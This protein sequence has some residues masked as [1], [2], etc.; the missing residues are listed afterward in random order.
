MRYKQ[1]TDDRQMTHRTQ[2]SVLTVGQQLEKY[3]GPVPTYDAAVR[4][5]LH[6][7]NTNRNIW[8]FE[9][10]ISTPVTLLFGS[11]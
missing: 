8:I 1:T 6:N 9:L 2:G 7:P 5:N 4:L 3:V 10:Q 11:V